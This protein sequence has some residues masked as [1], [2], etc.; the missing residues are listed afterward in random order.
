MIG[1]IINSTNPRQTQ[2]QSAGSWLLGEPC[3]QKVQSSVSKSFLYVYIILYH[4]HGPASSLFWADAISF[5]L[6]FVFHGFSMGFPD[7]SFQKPARRSLSPL[8]G[9]RSGKS[10]NCHHCGT[11]PAELICA[12]WISWESGLE[13]MENWK[14]KP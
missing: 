8:A 6:V 14:G 12:G 10:H 4:H 9:N 3:Q 2:N 13:N 5:T 11:R 7:D 1:A